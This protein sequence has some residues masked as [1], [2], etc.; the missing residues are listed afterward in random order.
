MGYLGNPNWS[1]KLIEKLPNNEGYDWEKLSYYLF[2]AFFRI[3]NKATNQNDVSNGLYYIE[4]FYKFAGHEKFKRLWDHNWYTMEI[5]FSY[6]KSIAADRIIA[7]WLKHEDYF[8]R[9]LGVK[10]LGWMRLNRSVRL[11]RQMALNENEHKN[12]IRECANSLA[13]IDSGES[14]KALQLIYETTD[15]ASEIYK[16]IA[17]YM[18]MALARVEDKEFIEKHYPE[19]SSMGGE[20]EAHTYYNIGL[21]GFDEN[22]WVDAVNSLD[23]IVRASIAPVYARR[24]GKSAIHKLLQMEREA[25]HD[26][27]R[28]LILSAL[29][30]A[31]EYEKKEE[32]LQAVYRLNTTSS[33][34]MLRHVWKREI[35]FA[36]Q[37]VEP[38]HSAIWENLQ[39]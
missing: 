34:R 13:V 9:Q 20:I 3:L 37:S 11:L 26:I 19:L 39:E 30:V 16:S 4:E 8:F 35:V 24:K 15:K 27:E 6:F 28:A 14:A 29:V 36:L 1:F 32:F 38:S 17:L 12:V 25:S 18:A 22:T 23:Y 33:L 7:E 5:L 10:A 31:G 21:L 2:V